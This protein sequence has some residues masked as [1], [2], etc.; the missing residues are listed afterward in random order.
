MAKAAVPQTD[1]PTALA[2]VEAGLLQERPDFLERGTRRGIEEQ[3][4]KDIIFPRLSL[5]Q[6]MTP[7]RK[8]S[9]PN[10][11]EGLEEGMLFNSLLGNIYGTEAVI[12]PIFFW[13]SRIMFRPMESGGGVLCMAPDG[14]HCQ[15]NNGGPCEHDKWGPAGEKP[16]CSELYNYLC[17]LPATGEQIMWSCKSTAIKAAKQ[18]G[19]L[20][21]LRNA[22]AFAGAYRLRTVPAKNNT[23]QE[24]FTLLVKPAGWVTKEMY[25]K[26]REMYEGI[27]PAVQEGRVA[28]DT[29]GM[30]HEGPDTD[31]ADPSFNTSEM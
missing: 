25:D 11:I 15:L 10:Y 14:Q 31:N 23:G 2:T 3:S 4:S 16:E 5:C 7:Q 30:E 18:L 22:D 8:K 6:S 13:K 29:T 27:K 20:I 12:V 19:S 1:S 26:C 17:Y 9:D 21:R 28:M 24:F